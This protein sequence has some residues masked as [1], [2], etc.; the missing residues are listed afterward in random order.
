MSL[1]WRF[2][3]H[4]RATLGDLLVLW[5]HS[6]EASVTEYVSTAFVKDGKFAM[7]GRE[8]FDRESKRWP[9]GEY[10]VT[11]ERRHATRSAA[12]N[13]F[14]WA[15]VLKLIA[16]HTGYTADELHE[17]F[18]KRFNS[19]R[20]SF[21]D[22]ATGEI[23]DED[24]IGQS[25]AKLNKVTFGEYVKSIE[26]W[27]YGELNITIPPP[28]PDWNAGHECDCGAVIKATETVC[29]RC[30]DEAAQSGEAA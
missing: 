25:T 15:V 8:R 29:P 11:I 13:A 26:A 6:S 24:V 10:T 5:R 22:K 30:R 16:E 23:R 28:D 27:A 19:K 21:V 9:D 20:L 12:Q 3:G 18:K 7:R 1:L 14:Y 4:H 17:Y 2:G